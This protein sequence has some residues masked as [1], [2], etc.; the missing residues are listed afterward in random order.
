LETAFRHPDIII[1][2]AQDLGL[3]PETVGIAG[4]PTKI[5]NVYSAT[6]EKKNIV[7]KGTPKKIVDELFEKFG[8]RISGAI[9][10]DLKTHYHKEKS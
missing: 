7:M 2:G 4:S 5:L 1:L 3:E 8:D 9:E 10:K 6:A